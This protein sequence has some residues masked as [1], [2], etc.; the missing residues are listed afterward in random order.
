[1]LCRVGLLSVYGDTE[2]RERM[3][4]VFPFFFAVYSE[5]YRFEELSLEPDSRDII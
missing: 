3:W 5:N 2:N 1:M 4:I